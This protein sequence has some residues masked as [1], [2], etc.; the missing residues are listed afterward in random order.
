MRANLWRVLNIQPGEERLAL[1][2]V[3]EM[4]LLGIGFNFVETSVFP[5]KPCFARDRD[6]DPGTY[7]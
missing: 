3:A 5:P 4:F 6:A 1:L 2:L 7:P